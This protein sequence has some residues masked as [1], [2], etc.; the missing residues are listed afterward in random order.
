M[1]KHFIDLTDFSK[2]EINKII[3]LAKN[4]KKNPTK[5]INVCKNKTLGMIFKTIV[6][7]KS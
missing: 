2:T 7:N 5:Y 3:S 1:I 6:K 4:I